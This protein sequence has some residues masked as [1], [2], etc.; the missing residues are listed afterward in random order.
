MEGTVN[1]ETGKPLPD[2]PRFHLGSVSKT[3]AGFVA[4]GLVK[5]GIISWDTRFFDLFPELKEAARKEYYTVT[6]QNLLSHRAGTPHRIDWSSYPGSEGSAKEQ[7]KAFARWI[8]SLKPEKPVFSKYNYSNAGTVIGAAMLEQAAG[9][10]Y[11]QIV[12][13]YLND[14]YRLYAQTGWP[15][16]FGVEQPRGH[17]PGGSLGL[18]NDDLIVFDKEY[19]NAFDSFFSPSGNYN[20]K[21]SDF[22]K[23]IQILLQGLAGKDLF[24]DKED[25]EYLHFG[26]PDYSL[27]WENGKK[28]SYKVTEHS[29][30][31]GNFF[32]HIA[33][34]PELGMG[35]GIMANSGIVNTLNPIKAA[36]KQA[37]LDGILKT[38]LEMYKQ[39]KLVL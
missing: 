24:L 3:I 5:E 12:R 35:I 21:L 31:K 15:V 7:R 19:V 13:N 18:K 23:Y 25:F 16:S 29:G 10:P 32:C 27:C 11:E 14:R 36:F 22:K 33:L 30:S 6:L 34:F 28:F 4:G 1:L 38:I 17:L 26:F 37:K 20:L 9:L 8:F 39:G 2:D